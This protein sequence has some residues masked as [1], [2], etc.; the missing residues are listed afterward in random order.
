MA[1]KPQYLAGKGADVIRVLLTDYPKAWAL[2]ELAERSGASLS[3]VSEISQSLIADRLALRDS[4]RGELR[5]T[6]PEDLLGRWAVANDF[7]SGQ[8]AAE[9]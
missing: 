5:L 3:W 8:P 6:N 1:P 9:Y 4:L 2:R 7:S